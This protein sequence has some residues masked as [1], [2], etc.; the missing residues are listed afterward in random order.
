[1]T[2]CLDSVFDKKSPQTKI[3]RFSAQTLRSSN[4]V[5]GLKSKG[6]FTHAF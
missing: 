4:Y 1:M 6:T 2:F 5:L 3:K